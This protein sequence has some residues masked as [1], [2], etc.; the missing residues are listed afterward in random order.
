[1]VG[2]LPDA[3][4]SLELSLE[5]PQAL[6]AIADI[7]QI[8]IS[9]RPF[10]VLLSMCNSFRFSFM[11]YWGIPSNELRAVQLCAARSEYGLE[12][13]GHLLRLIAT[14]DCKHNKRQDVR[15]HSEQERGNVHAARL[16]LE[17]Q[18]DRSA[19]EQR[20]ERRADR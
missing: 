10:T 16:Q 19:E 13:S 3:D 1:M 8:A 20:A 7:R 11:G 14:R 15:S 17:L 2:P 18:T 9:S 6:S 5:L 12:A 4:A